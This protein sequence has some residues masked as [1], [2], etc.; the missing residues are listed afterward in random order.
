M[1]V[2]RDGLTPTKEEIAW[3]KRQTAQV[4]HDAKSRAGP[5]WSWIGP[6]FQECLVSREIVKVALCQAEETLAK[7]PA[8]ANIVALARSA[9]GAIE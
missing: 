5:A 8:L 1:S 3:C 4:L 9:Y 6:T 2:P 7:N